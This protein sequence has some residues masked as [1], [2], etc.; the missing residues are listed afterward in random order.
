[1]SVLYYMINKRG[2][3]NFF[4]LQDTVSKVVIPQSSIKWNKNR[5]NPSW[6]KKL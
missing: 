4:N 5:S 1:M 3:A 6:A 2:M